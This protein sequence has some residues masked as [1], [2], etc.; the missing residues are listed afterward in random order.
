MIYG[1]VL[2]SI[3][4]AYDKVLLSHLLDL[5]FKTSVVLSPLILII[6]VVISIVGPFFTS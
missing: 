4:N 3:G 5:T 2:D 1:Q 6:I